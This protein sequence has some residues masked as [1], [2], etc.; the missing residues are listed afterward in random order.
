MF[1]VD[2]TFC[3]DLPGFLRRSLR[4]T[5]TVRRALGEKTAVKDVIEACGVPHVE[6]DL[7]VALDATGTAGRALEFAFPVDAPVTLAIFPVPAPPDLLPGA[8]RLQPR[9]CARF[10]ADGHLGT[11]TR[12]LRLLGLDTA[13]ERDADDPRLLEIMTQEHRT[14]LTRDR[15]LLMHAIVHHGYCPRSHDPEEQAREVLRRFELMSQPPRF[16]PWSRCLRCNGLLRSVPRQAVIEALAQEPRTLRYY[17]D[18]RRCTECGR[19]YWHGSH[20]GQLSARLARMQC[21]PTGTRDRK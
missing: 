4:G 9:G 17:G 14:L 1:L 12:H 16:A 6:V 20:A 19:I 5:A 7:I 3:G 2:L 13:Y 15:R 18:F 10:I 21:L 8:P 11:L